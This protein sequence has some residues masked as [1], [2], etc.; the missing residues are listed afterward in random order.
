M[1]TTRLEKSYWKSLWNQFD[2]ILLDREFFFW[3]LIFCD[4]FLVVFAIKEE[5]DILYQLSYTSQKFSRIITFLEW[6]TLLLCCRVSI[7]VYTT[8]RAKPRS[9]RAT[10]GTIASPREILT[11]VPVP[12]GYFR[13]TNELQY[14]LFYTL[15]LTKLKALKHES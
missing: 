2:K 13:L 10:R 1:H 6:R 8:C 12:F 5:L 4:S 11:L 7:H 9:L 3:E 14:E 15:I